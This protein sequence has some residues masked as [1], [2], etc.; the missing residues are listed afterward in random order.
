MKLFTLVLA[1][2][3]VLPAVLAQSTTEITKCF[4]AGGCGQWTS[5]VLSKCSSQL[6]ASG[7]YNNGVL[8][9]TKLSSA[10]DLL[11]CVCSNNLATDF[12]NNCLDCLSGSLKQQ[13]ET[14]MSSCSSTSSTNST[15]STS[16]TTNSTVS[17]TPTPSGTNKSNA[18]MAKTSYPWKLTGAGAVI[19]GGLLLAI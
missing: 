6:V 7:L 12:Q 10:T 2:A 15:S 9:P 16:S 5:S 13:A 17:G 3:A 11:A 1:S 8:D 18:I 19:V 14:A 4:T